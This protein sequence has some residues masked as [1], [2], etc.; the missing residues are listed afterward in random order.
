MKAT[1]LMRQH[2]E[3]LTMTNPHD[4]IT[5][6][7]ALY[8]LARNPPHPDDDRA[9]LQQLVLAPAEP[10]P[11]APTDIARLPDYWDERRR[12]QGKPDLSRCAAELRLALAA[13][14]RGAR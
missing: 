7:D 13:A 4:V 9:F 2:E 12:R 5:D 1:A 8:E 10:Q 3:T 6:P 14:A 11:D